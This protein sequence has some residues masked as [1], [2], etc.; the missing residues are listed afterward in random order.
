MSSLD[1]PS[2][3][4]LFENAHIAI[5]YVDGVADGIIDVDLT[6]M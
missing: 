4:S 1:C 5:P 6:V 3:I 2:H